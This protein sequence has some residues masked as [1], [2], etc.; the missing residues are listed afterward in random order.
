[1]LGLSEKLYYISSCYFF[2]LLFFLIYIYDTGKTTIVATVTHFE[3]LL[4]SRCFRYSAW[5]KRASLSDVSQGFIWESRQSRSVSGTTVD[6]ELV[7]SKSQA[8]C[9]SPLSFTVWNPR[10]A[11]NWQRSWVRLSYLGLAFA[12]LLYFMACVVCSHMR[13]FSFDLLS[14]RRSARYACPLQWV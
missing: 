11:L 4:N 2:L 13:N 9:A 6:F 14:R 10:E 3:W 7:K 1:M 5:R 8:A 12:F